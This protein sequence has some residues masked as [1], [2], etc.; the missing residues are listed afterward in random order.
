MAIENS[1]VSYTLRI[2]KEYIINLINSLLFSNTVLWDGVDQF[3]EM[4]IFTSE[5]SDGYRMEQRGALFVDNRFGR[6]LRVLTTIEEDDPAGTGTCR[7]CY[8]MAGIKDQMRIGSSNRVY[9]PFVS[10]LDFSVAD[11]RL[12]VR[13]PFL[14]FADNT[15]KNKEI[16]SARVMSLVGHL[17]SSTFIVIDE[18]ELFD[19][20][21]TSTLSLPPTA[22]DPH[23]NL[24]Y[25]VYPPD[26]LEYTE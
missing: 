15:E 25:G 11:L 9:Y 12:G 2:T 18:R 16:N 10:P 26:G 6:I 5:Q 7:V 4:P 21:L 24:V 14:T 17:V 1:R 19:D 3:N 22:S 20:L 23:F 8:H 13:T